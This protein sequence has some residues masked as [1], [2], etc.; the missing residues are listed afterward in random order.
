MANEKNL[1]QLPEHLMPNFLAAVIKE[2]ERA[3][4]D[5]EPDDRRDTT[6]YVTREIDLVDED[7]NIFVGDVDIEMQMTYNTP[8]YSV[9]YCGGWD[10]EDDIWYSE[11]VVSAEIYDEEK[12]DVVEVN[13]YVPSGETSF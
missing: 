3:I 11:C 1:P 5:F 10:T 2:A 9:G 7:D 12:D 6:L 13:Y 4:E 8:D